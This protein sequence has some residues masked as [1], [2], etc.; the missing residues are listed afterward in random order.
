VSA[1]NAVNEGPLS[2]ERSATPAGTSVI[3]SDQFE[4]TVASG[5]GSADVGGSWSVSVASKTKVQNGEA[6]VYG[7]TGGNQDV[8]AWTSTVAD[9]MELLGLVRLNASNPVGASYA[10]RLMA[11]A[12]ADA[13]NGYSARVV[14]TSSGAL[15]WG[16]SRVAN[17]GG[18]GSL[19]L[20]SGSLLSS[21]AAGTQWWIRLRVQGTSIKV[22]YWLN[23]TNEPS[24]WNSSVTDSF[25][26]S[27]RAALGAFANSGISPPFPDTG[28]RSITALDLGTA[29]PA[30][31]V[32]LSPPTLYAPEPRH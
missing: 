15:T 9:D 10:P 32:R 18:T 29:P 5:F 27:G 30:S 25:W 4:R 20:A 13:R 1:V 6:V 11:R 23:G 14:H 19:A 17:A 12:Q 24:T 2:N 21:G 16:L 7:W 31:P 8:Q 28:F 26:S 3:V 22:R